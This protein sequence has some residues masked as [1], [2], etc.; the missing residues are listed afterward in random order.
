VPWSA[1]D[2]GEGLLHNILVLKNLLAWI[3]SLLHPSTKR[4]GRGPVAIVKLSQGGV[5]VL[6]WSKL[7]FG[8]DPI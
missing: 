8:G 3:S 7:G 1:R 6:K 5:N 2:R 4:Q